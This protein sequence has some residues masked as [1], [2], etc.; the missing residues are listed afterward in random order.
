MIRSLGVKGTR[1]QAAAPAVGLVEVSRL[2]ASSPTTQSEAE[3]QAI[4]LIALSASMCVVVQ[5]LDPSV[6]LVDVRTFPWS[7]PT[8][9]KVVVGQDAERAALTVVYGGGVISC[10]SDHDNGEAARA[11]SAG[12]ARTPRTQRTA[13]PTLRSVDVL[14]PKKWVRADALVV[15]KAFSLA[16]SASFVATEPLVCGHEPNGYQDRLLT[17]P[18][19]YLWPA[20]H[21]A[22][23]R[24]SARWQ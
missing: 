19:R 22:L 1:F 7:S 6:G 12:K 13:T 4:A 17:C 11:W 2:P 9:Q 20:H 3:G 24:R 23:P 18:T 15:I 14:P 21:Y 5:A 8:A 10:G 16:A